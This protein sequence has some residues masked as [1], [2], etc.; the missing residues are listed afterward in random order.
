MA[1]QP[2][3]GLLRGTAELGREGATSYLFIPALPLVKHP[4]F[5]ENACGG[6]ALGT[7]DEDAEVTFGGALG[8]G[9]N[10]SPNHRSAQAALACPQMTGDSSWTPHNWLGTT[11]KL[12]S[13]GRSLHLVAEPRMTDRLQDR[14]DGRY[15]GCVLTSGTVTGAPRT[16]STF[17]HR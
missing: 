11:M 10:P 4:D 1:T 8:L 6:L 13:A 5:A 12:L 16:H 14:R 2:V 9:P 3:P 15:G 7:E 17:L